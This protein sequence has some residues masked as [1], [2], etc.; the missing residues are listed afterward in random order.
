MLMWMLIGIG[1]A[2]LFAILI[3]RNAIADDKRRKL[4]KRPSTPDTWR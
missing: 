4:I 2:T 1:V 3:I